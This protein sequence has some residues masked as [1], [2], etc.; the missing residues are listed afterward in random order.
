[1]ANVGSEVAR[2]LRSR[3]SGNRERSQRAFER[4]LEL[5]DLSSADPRWRGPRLRE[6]RRAREEFCRLHLGDEED[7]SWDGFEKYFLAFAVA[8]RH[9]RREAPG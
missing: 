7:R 5:F 6:I 8:A 9:P 1:M 3:R 4:A 2:T